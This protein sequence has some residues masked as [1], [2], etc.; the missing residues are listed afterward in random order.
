ALAGPGET[1]ISAAVRDQLSAD[2]DGEI[3][4]LGECH[5]KHIETP[6]RAYRLEIARKQSRSLPTLEAYTLLLGGIGLMHRS[7]PR[8]FHRS[9][10][11]AFQGRGAE[12]LEETLHAVQLSPLD[13]WRYYYDSLCATAALA[14]RDYERAIALAQRSLKSNRMHAST[15][16]VIAIAS[17]ELGHVEEARATVAQLLALD[18]TLTVSR[19][20]ARSP[21][22]DYE[23]GAAWARA[24]E[25]AGL[26][27]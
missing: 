21:A 17:A 2:L 23:T 24:L 13:P 3:T 5:L 20:R 9:T 7:K 25:R 19:Y 15:L 14:A 4:D 12:A 26:P 16:R 27:E 18:P 22:D 6:H 11:R 1:V 8:A 10:L